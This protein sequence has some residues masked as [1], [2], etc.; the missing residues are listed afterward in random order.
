MNTRKWIYRNITPRIM[1][2]TGLAAIPSFLFQDNV[3]LKAV[4]TGLF[5]LLSVIEGKRFKF[6]PPLIMIASITLIN[7]FNPIGRIILTLG[8]LHITY[9]ALYLGLIKGLTLV[10]LIYLSRSAVRS[11][12]ILPGRF[13]RVIGRTFYYFDRINERWSQT[14]KE[15]RGLLER[16]DALL[17]DIDV[18][19]QETPI[20][21]PEG[22]RDRRIRY[23][24]P[25]GPSKTPPDAAGKGGTVQEGKT[26]PKG[27]AVSAGF[28][29]L[30]W[31]LF[32]LRYLPGLSRGI[33]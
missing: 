25:D 9:G 2:I 14:K 22:G 26:T 5:V 17:L 30:S 27:Y 13:G 16:L 24:R 32:A 23:G 31:G 11:D 1:I 3:I 10:G 4:Q 28:L 18:P 19:P 8:R 6:L 33:G 29:L 15:R 21:T 12:L 7:L 20:K